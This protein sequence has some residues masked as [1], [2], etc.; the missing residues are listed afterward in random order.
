[1]W[2][3]VLYADMD[4]AALQGALGWEWG[5]GARAL[6]AVLLLAWGKPLPP[7]DPGYPR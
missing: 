3:S 2:K 1:M 6:S 5:A 4:C 7:P